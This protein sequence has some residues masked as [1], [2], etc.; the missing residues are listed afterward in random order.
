[1]GSNEQQNNHS[2][3]NGRTIARTNARSLTPEELNQ[4]GG[5]CRDISTCYSCPQANMEGIDMDG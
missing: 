1:M 4:V 2:K 5:A 3:L